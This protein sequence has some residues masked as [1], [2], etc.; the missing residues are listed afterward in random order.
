MQDNGLAQ[1][2]MQAFFQLHRQK[3]RSG[4][5]QGL[6]PGEMRV[7]RS[8]KRLDQGEGVMVTQLVTLLGVTRPFITQTSTALVKRCLVSRNT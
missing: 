3:L 8:I 1:R 6:N 4:Q 2:L 5:I 7:L